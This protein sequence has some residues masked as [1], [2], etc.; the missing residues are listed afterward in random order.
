M[1]K[2]AA[3]FVIMICMCMS[4]T[5]NAE[6]SVV[7]ELDFDKNTVDDM[8]IDGWLFDENTERFTIENGALSYAWTANGRAIRYWEDI[9]DYTVTFEWQPDDL[10]NYNENAYKNVFAIRLPSYLPSG[11]EGLKLYE[12]DNGDNDKSSF[13]GTVGI[14]FSGFGTTFEIAIH[15]EDSSRS[16]G[17]GSKAYKF[18][19]PEGKTFN[20]FQTVTIKD[21]GETVSFSAAGTLL[22]S[23]TLSDIAEK[24]IDNFSGDV[25]SCAAVKDASGTEV[26]KVENAIVPVEGSFAFLNRGNSG[27][28]GSFKI[29]QDIEPETPKPEE[30][31][32]PDGSAAATQTAETVPTQTAGKPDLSS[33][34]PDNED[35]NKEEN[36]STAIIIAAA[37]AVCIIAAGAVTAVIIKKRKSK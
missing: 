36:G 28:I 32:T 21:E 18:T 7:Y 33:S 24:E 17:I 35:K 34:S 9:N 10:A 11:F 30:T 37:A 15:T 25:Y 8:Y 23:V 4:I 20:D 14:Y 1:K 5:A 6:E 27:K 13:L 2:A 29:I 16:W 31:N 19:L 22:G 26:L 12:P 3:L